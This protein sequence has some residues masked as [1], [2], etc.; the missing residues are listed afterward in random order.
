MGIQPV[1]ATVGQVAGAIEQ[2]QDAALFW[3]IAPSRRSM[4]SR[5]AAGVFA[6]HHSATSPT[7]ASSLSPARTRITI[8]AGSICEP[9]AA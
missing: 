3:L 9:S 2:H 8:C 6:S 5:S 1:A 4:D 7:K